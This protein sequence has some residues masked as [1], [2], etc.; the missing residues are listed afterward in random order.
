MAAL[1]QY[2]KDNNFYG[3]YTNGNRTNRGMKLSH[4]NAGNAFL[5]NKVIDIENVIADH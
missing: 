5:E 3:R 2:S 4:W 1:L